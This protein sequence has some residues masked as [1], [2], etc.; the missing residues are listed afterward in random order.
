ME[1]K[2]GRKK[3]RD[4][5][6]RRGLFALVSN[7]PDPF[8]REDESLLFPDVGADGLLRKKEDRQRPPGDR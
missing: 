7:R 2:G 1:N 8:V 4:T 5:W 6:K 3:P